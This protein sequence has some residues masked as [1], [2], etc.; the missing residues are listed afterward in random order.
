MAI[1]AMTAE[2][3]RAFEDA[4][5]PSLLLKGP[6]VA[7]WLYPSESRPYGDA[8]LLVD[9]AQFRHAARVLRKL[10]FGDASVALGEHAHTYRRK[11]DGFVEVVD[12]HRTLPLVGVRPTDAWL[13]F[14]EV[15]ETMEVGRATV[16]V[17]AISRRLLHL[18]I[19]ACQHVFE[20]T[21][22]IEDVRRAL[23]AAD[24]VCWQDAVVLSRRLR[25]EDALAAGLCLFPEGEE[26][27]RSLGL[28]TE[29]RGLLRMVASENPDP[30]AYQ[31][32]RILD[33]DGLRERLTLLLNPLFM[34]PPLLRQDSAMAHR[35]RGGLVAAYLARPFVLA[36]RLAPALVARRRI[37]H[38][39]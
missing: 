5:I 36:A 28:T 4:D 14:N 8:D 32:Q 30:A 22:P 20:A 16:R 38:R 9:P 27:S 6:A 29:R 1:D 19:H 13:A 25:A 37:L 26:L 21:G 7:Q 15:A 33:A 31:L 17:P 2:V 23:T 3:V 24:D 10:G 11:R 18:A 39:Q 35:G 12:L 34:S